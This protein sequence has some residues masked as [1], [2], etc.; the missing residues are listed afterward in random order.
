VLTTV[1]GR[2]RVEELF[3]ATLARAQKLEFDRLKAVKSVLIT[4]NATLASLNT[5]LQLSSERSAL[6]SEAFQPVSDLNSIIEQ[7][8]TGPYRPRPTVWTDFHHEA[9]DVRFG[10]DLRHWADME[11]EKPEVASRRKM[12]DVFDALLNALKEGYPS[13]KSDEGKRTPLLDSCPLY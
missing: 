8:R 1:F 11:N 5:P 6:L 12:P 13:L 2:L 9:T 4:Y 7:Y 3:S 10:I